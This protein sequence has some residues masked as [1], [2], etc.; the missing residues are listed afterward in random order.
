[1]DVWGL[2]ASQGTAMTFTSKAVTG[3]QGA[4]L[5]KWLANFRAN[6]GIV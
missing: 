1:M 5:G 6:M 3:R 2:V 4:G